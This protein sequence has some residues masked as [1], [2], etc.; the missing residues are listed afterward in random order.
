MKT[1]LSCTALTVALAFTAIPADAK[2]C[3]KARWSEVS[4][5]TIHATMAC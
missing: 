3:I 5:G 4:L 1:I 2:G